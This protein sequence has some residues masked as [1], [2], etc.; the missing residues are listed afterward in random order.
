MVCRQAA[1]PPHEGSGTVRPVRRVDKSPTT[2]KK[3]GNTAPPKR[4]LLCCLGWCLLV[5]DG[6]ASVLLSFWVVLTPLL[7]LVGGPFCPVRFLSG[8]AF[9][10]LWSAAVSLPPLG[11]GDFNKFGEV[12]LS[13]RSSRVEHIDLPH[14][15]PKIKEKSF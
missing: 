4:V 7:P 14:F 9:L 1:L 8:V 13:E 3:K 11:G 5:L 15:I 6:G 2:H 10:L 12:L